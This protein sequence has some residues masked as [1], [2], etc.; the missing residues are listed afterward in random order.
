MPEDSK[1][2]DDAWYSELPESE[3]DKLYSESV[4]RVKTAVEQG[5]GF[6]E[7]SK[8]VDVQNGETRS[9]ILDDALKI[10]I[11]EQHFGKKQPLEKLAKKLKLPVEKL[12]TARQEMLADVELAAIQKYKEETGQSGNS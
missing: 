8:L 4:N 9:L 6:E 12:M 10:I 7:A 11:A 3:E 5:L 1:K 2:P